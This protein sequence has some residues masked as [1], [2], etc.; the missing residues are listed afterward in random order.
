MTSLAWALA[1]LTGMFVVAALG[2]LVSEEIRG[3][4]D[5]VPRGILRLA[6]VRLDP[7][8]RETICKEEWLP[9]LIYVLRGAESRPITRLIRGSNFALGLLVSARRITRHLA[10]TGG[11]GSLVEAAMDD[12][13]GLVKAA[14][15]GDFKA[16]RTLID[17]YAPL[18]WVTMRPFGLGSNVTADVSQTVWLRLVDNLDRFEDPVHIARWLVA[19]TRREVLRVHRPAGEGMA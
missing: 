3:W 16:W 4:L 15:D 19:L 14:V 10:Q 1:G 13:G 6:A 5:L 12:L 7:K 17:L 11:A 8:L 9:E 18:V 2:D